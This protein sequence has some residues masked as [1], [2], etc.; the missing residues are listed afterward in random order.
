MAWNRPT[1]T[2]PSTPSTPAPIGTF[3]ALAQEE[4]NYGG[5]EPLQVSCVTDHRPTTV[6]DVRRLF[7]AALS[8]S[9]D[10]AAWI[11]GVS[12]GD[13][14]TPVA[15]QVLTFKRGAKDRGL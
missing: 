11:G 2:T 12:V 15:G 1:N 3:T 10:H 5:N 9:T 8:L 6:G 14:T 4:S 7:G 13:E